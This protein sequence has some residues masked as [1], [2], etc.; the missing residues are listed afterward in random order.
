MQ[1]REN[2]WDVQIAAAER[3]DGHGAHSSCYG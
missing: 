2:K 3:D 1:S